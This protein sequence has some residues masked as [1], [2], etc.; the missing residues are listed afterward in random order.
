MK[1][2]GMA[3]ALLIL[4]SATADAGWIFKKKK[5]AEEVPGGHPAQLVAPNGVVVPPWASKRMQES[6]VPLFGKPWGRRPWALALSSQATP[7]AVYARADQ[8]G[9]GAGPVPGYTNGPNLGGNIPSAP[10][11]PDNGNGWGPPP[12]LR[13]LFMPNTYPF[14][15]AVNSY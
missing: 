2:I 4:V 12:G 7:S 8:L 6:P 13:N 5:A 9:F 10:V 1:R 15:S 11:G 14:L 3:L